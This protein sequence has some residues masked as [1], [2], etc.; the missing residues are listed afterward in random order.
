MAMLIYY[1]MYIVAMHMHATLAGIMKGP[2]VCSCMYARRCTQMIYIYRVHL[3][4]HLSDVAASEAYSR[5]ISPCDRTLVALAVELIAWGAVCVS[6]QASVSDLLSANSALSI[7][8]KFV[9]L[10]NAPFIFGHTPE[11]GIV[12]FAPS[13]TAWAAA[14]KKIG[15]NNECAVYCSVVVPTKLLHQSA[16]NQSLCAV[17]SCFTAFAP[18]STAAPKAVKTCVAVPG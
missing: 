12:M 5:Q 16:P 15:E 1:V 2:V 10:A 3:R 4:Y 17:V 13:D 9:Q 14:A 8:T 6:P 7:T 11:V 18:C